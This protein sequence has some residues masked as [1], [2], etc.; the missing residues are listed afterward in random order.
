MS[1]GVELRFF[2]GG[3]LE[4][5]SRESKICPRGLTI[6]GEIENFSNVGVE[7]FS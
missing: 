3:I 6:F 1:G 4:A 7:A 5:T 2:H